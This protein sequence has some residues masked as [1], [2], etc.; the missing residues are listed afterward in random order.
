[1]I[2]RRRWQRAAFMA[3]STSYTT[4]KSQFTNSEPS[5]T[6]SRSGPTGTVTIY[7]TTQSI[8]YV[9]SIELSSTPPPPSWLA[10]SSPSQPRPHST[11][12]P[13]P[14]PSAFDTPDGEATSIIIILDTPTPLD[15]RP[16]SK[17]L[18]VG[19]IVGGSIAAL[20][21]IQMLILVFC[22]AW[23]RRKREAALALAFPFPV[24]RPQDDGGLVGLGR[25]LGIRHRSI[26]KGS[27]GR[28]IYYAGPLSQIS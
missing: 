8:V 25:A 11:P 9:G 2:W 18:P 20:A 22:F 26:F 13:P 7:R 3:L 5:S 12:P 19:P 14:V 1:M 15:G 10:P 17:V 23:R 24:D 4:T 28:A 21:L 6:S 27:S 16:K